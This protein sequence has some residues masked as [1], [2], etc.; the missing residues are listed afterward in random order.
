MGRR[1]QIPSQ[2][3]LQAQAMAAQSQGMQKKQIGTPRKVN[4]GTPVSNQGSSGSRRPTLNRSDGMDDGHMVIPTS[5]ATVERTVNRKTDRAGENRTE[6][7]K[8]G[9]QEWGG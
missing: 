5:A 7:R 1:A 8:I 2:K 4:T 6:P 9:T 3:A